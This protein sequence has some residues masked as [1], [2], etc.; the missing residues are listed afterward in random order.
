MTNTEYTPPSAALDTVAQ[1]DYLVN[2]ASQ[3]NAELGDWTKDA[4]VDD[5]GYFVHNADAETISSKEVWDNFRNSS[6]NI[7]GGQRIY[8][9][10]QALYSIRSQG[11]ILDLSQAEGL[12]KAV[13][14]LFAE[15]EG[16]KT[17]FIAKDPDSLIRNFTSDEDKQVII[18]MLMLIKNQLSTDP[19]ANIAQLTEAVSL[20]NKILKDVPLKPEEMIKMEPMFQSL[21]TKLFR[22][23][24][25]PDNIANLVKGAIEEFAESRNWLQRAYS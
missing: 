16:L 7:I 15:Y 12:H 23:E 6:N 1:V 13:T 17:A 19:E 3:E 9:V 20:F 22:A 10:I 2:S 25:Q 24:V 8:S 5:E 18:G 11:N 4:K 14:T 21:G